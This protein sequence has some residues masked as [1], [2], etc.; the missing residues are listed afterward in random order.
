MQL[1]NYIILC[2]G[3]G[4]RLWPITQTI[5]K[6]MV[7]I[8][9]KPI[10][11]WIVQAIYPNA[12]KIV[13]IISADPD[14]QKIADYFLKTELA[15]KIEFVKQKKID[16]T[17]S[18]VLCA[19]KNIGQNESFIVLNG[20]TF[21]Q[22][23]F[24]KKISENA[25]E[26]NWFLM[27]KK[28]DD[29]SP[30]GLLEIKQN[31]LNGIIEKPQEKTGGLI[32]TGCFFVSS[33]FWE[34]LQNIK[35][36]PRGEYEATDAILNFAKIFGMRV[37]EFE[38]YWNDVGYFWNYLDSNSFAIDNLMEEK[39]LGEVDNAASIR[40]K[41]Y[42]GKGTQIKA[43]TVIEGPAFI[44]PDCIVG[45][46]ATLRPYSCI[47]S[48]NH[49]GTGTEI[50]NSMILEYADAHGAYIGDS[51]ICPK[52]NLGAGTRIANLKFDETTIFAKI[53]G[54]RVDSKRRK[55]GVVIGEGTKTGVNVSI[56]CGVLIGC[57]CKIYPNNF[58]RTN[59]ENNTIF[60]ETDLE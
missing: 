14:G 33:D 18:A 49:I 43:G 20:D 10:L 55:L 4:E 59:L 34:I 46:N 12:K 36:S 25:I 29:A 50:K 26:N 16:G 42:I 52:V 6:A 7:R 53:K 24:Y 32:N 17:A 51:I 35:L 22:P 37:S 39:V 31:K 19:K 60:K 23:E 44:G 47:E 54:N 9:G 11:H 30:Y 28:I 45:P 1:N 38:G 2:A 27:G 15:E 13:L 58:V 8:I 57:N 3:K 56:N 41:I 5:P 48:N 40:G 21:A